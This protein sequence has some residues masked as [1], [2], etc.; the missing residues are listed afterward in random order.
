MPH[1]R[2]LLITGFE[3]FDGHAINVSWELAQALDGETVGALNCIA[4]QLP[5]VFERSLQ[6]LERAIEV[7]DPV[8]VLALGQAEGRADLT[9]ERFA[10]NLRD[11]RIPDNAG[12]QPVDQTIV[13][14]GPLALPTTLPV[15][16]L[17]QAL[18][19]AGH[20]VALS[21]T[22][23]TFVCNE[24]FYGLQYHLRG[25][26]VPSGFIHL[27]VLPEQTSLHST[28]IA[29]DD[30]PIQPDRVVPSRPRAVQEAALRELIRLMAERIEATR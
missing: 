5:C 22:A 27:P 18:R 17:E 24:V 15:R 3:A 13:A 1:S 19:A 2:Q 28:R 23:G 21:N 12:A 8:L 9:L 20:P 16:A 25:R 6:A 11:A 26:A 29:R 30:A 7:T 10:I 4:C 14:D